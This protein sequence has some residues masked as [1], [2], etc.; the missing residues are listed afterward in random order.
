MRN[1]VK[2]ALRPTYSVDTSGMWFDV[3]ERGEVAL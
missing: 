3:S 1:R 2:V